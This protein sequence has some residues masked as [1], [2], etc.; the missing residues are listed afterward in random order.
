MAT[1]RSRFEAR[2]ERENLDQHMHHEKPTQRDPF[3]SLTE[4]TKDATMVSKGHDG[5]IHHARSSHAGR[6]IMPT[7]PASFSVFS[8]VDE[9]SLHEIP[10]I[11]SPGMI[12][13]SKERGKE[14]IAPSSL[15]QEQD[16]YSYQKQFFEENEEMY[17]KHDDYPDDFDQEYMQYYAS[18]TFPVV[19]IDSEDAIEDGAVL[20]DEKQDLLMQRE[21]DP[22]IAGARIQ[23]REVL[24]ERKQPHFRKPTKE[25]YEDVLLEED[26][27][28]ESQGLLVDMRGN[29]ADEEEEEYYDDDDDDD[30]GDDDYE[31]DD[32]VEIV[33]DVDAEEELKSSVLAPGIIDIDAHDQENPMFVAEYAEDIFSHLRGREAEFMCRPDYM[34]NFQTDISPTMRSILMDWLNEVSQEFR[35]RPETLF[36]AANFIDRYL[37]REIVHRNRLQLVGIT[38][39]FIASKYEEIAP[40]VVHNFAYITDNTYR[41]DEILE[42]ERNVLSK[43]DFALTAPTTID[44]LP[45]FLKAA[46]ATPLMTVLA[47]YLAELTL[48][49]YRFV[50]FPPSLVAASCVCLAHHA[51]SLPVWTKT[52]EHYT[53]Y[54]LE[55]LEACVTELTTVFQL[56]PH[57]SLQAVHEKYSHSHLF[58]VADRIAAPRH[59]P[60]F[61]DDDR[62][63]QRMGRGQHHDLPS[64]SDGMD[65]TPKR[66]RST[67]RG[68]M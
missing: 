46:F 45:R 24:K 36:L 50:Q 14:D 8:D 49:E 58:H 51:L 41:V 67:H 18:E 17:E 28:E 35:L 60:S 2:R 48:Q 26:I 16:I 30:D 44:F 39:M 10:P 59:P 22:F 55:D 65:V 54:S 29:C 56:A 33:D 9:G 7:G 1:R 53:H 15:S 23:H 37:S 42:M 31:L 27:V 43:L 64:D 47:H 52:L 11:S 21:M 25:V 6:S 38:S 4:N 57:R 34:Q 3:K 19:S 20:D 32:D 61:H 62:H 12:I 40:P 63:H 68:H 5:D 66:P 13:E